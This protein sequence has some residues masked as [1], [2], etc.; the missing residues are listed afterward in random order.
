VLESR[1][2]VLILHSAAVDAAEEALPA[3]ARHT[4]VNLELMTATDRSN[5]IL[6]WR[7]YARALLIA[8]Q[9]DMSDIMRQTMHTGRERGGGG[10]LCD[11]VP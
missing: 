6:W 7:W 10:V 4:P 3:V 8:S 5:S 9:A 1:E 2:R 11:E